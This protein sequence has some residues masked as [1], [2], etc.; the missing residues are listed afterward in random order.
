MC[1]S[2]ALCLMWGDGE[3]EEEKSFFI[4]IFSQIMIW[5]RR[6]Y[7]ERDV[8]Q[9]QG[10]A[11]R[12]DAMNVYEIEIEFSQLCYLRFFSLNYDFSLYFSYFP[13]TLVICVGDRF[14]H[15]IQIGIIC[16]TTFP[17]IWLYFSD[18]PPFGQRIQK[19]PHSIQHH[20]LLDVSVISPPAELPSH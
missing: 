11:V 1:F 8:C 14:V 10:D 3:W 9:W 20:L 7:A 17:L 6:R 19:H 5:A 18:F 4:Y 13:Y 2:L 15:S 12:R 16:S